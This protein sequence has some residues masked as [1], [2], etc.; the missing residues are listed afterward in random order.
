MA[1]VLCEC[2][3]PGS[4]VAAYAAFEGGP[5]N[6]QGCGSKDCN[7]YKCKNQKLSK[8]PTLTQSQLRR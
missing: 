3:C 7:D 1:W 5:Y 6:A 8:Y 4:N 2:D